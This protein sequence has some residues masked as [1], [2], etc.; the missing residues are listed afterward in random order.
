MKNMYLMNFIMINYLIG[1]FMY[2]LNRKHLLIILLS[3]EFI[4]LNLFFLI[5]L[6]TISLGNSMYFMVLFM[7]LSVCEGVL[8][9]SILMYMIRIFGN[10][11]VRIFSVI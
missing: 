10:D 8:G 7:V 4:M 3:L 9:I 5:Y 1:N 2:S 11:Y 6:Y